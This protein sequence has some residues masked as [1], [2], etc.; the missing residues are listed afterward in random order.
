V[1][2]RSGKPAQPAPPSGRPMTGRILRIVRGQGQGFIRDE[3]GREVFFVRADL[4]G[5]K[6]NDLTIADPVAFELID[7]RVS[8]P[9]GVHVRKVDARR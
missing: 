8:G 5:V 4:I 7:D 2:K 3:D 1:T 6:F 9:R